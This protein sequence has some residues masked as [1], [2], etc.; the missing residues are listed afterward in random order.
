MGVRLLCRVVLTV[1]D[2]WGG[3]KGHGVNVRDQCARCDNVTG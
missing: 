3:V 2:Q 1:S